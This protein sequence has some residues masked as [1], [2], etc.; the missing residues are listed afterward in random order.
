MKSLYRYFLRGLLTV[1]PLVL[2]VYLLFIFL[3]WTESLALWVLHP[4]IGSVYVPGMGLFFGILTILGIGF[5]MSKPQVRE[6]LAFVEVPF[7][8]LPVVKASTPR[9]RLSRTTSRRPARRR[10]TRW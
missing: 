8:R 7:T 9:S 6:A 10:R 4:V 3:A 5:L 1:L 2:T